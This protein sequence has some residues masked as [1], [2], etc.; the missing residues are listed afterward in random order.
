MTTKRPAPPVVVECWC[1]MVA[2]MDRVRLDKFTRETWKKFDAKSRAAER[3]KCPV[4]GVA[5]VMTRSD[6]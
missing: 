1:L 5:I 3:R 4:C 6:C 2:T